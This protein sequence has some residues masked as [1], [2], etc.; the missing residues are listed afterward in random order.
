VDAAERRVEPAPARDAVDVDD[1]LRCRQRAELVV[2]QPRLALDLAEDAEVPAREVDVRD[3][4]GVEHGPL[5]GEVLPRRQPPRI[6]AALAQ[7]RLRLAAEE[8]HVTAPVA[9]CARLP[10]LASWR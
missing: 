1:H 3:V 4:A 7:L 9:R 5:L 6:Q 8:R 10:T 2:A